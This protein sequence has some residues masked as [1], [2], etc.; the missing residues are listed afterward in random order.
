[1]EA[2]VTIDGIT[3]NSAQVMS[4]RV[5]V[6]GMITDYANDPARLGTDEHGVRMRELY[7]ARLREVEAMLVAG[8]PGATRGG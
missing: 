1:M 2:N 3:L 7:L 4:V 5:A 8:C 6:S